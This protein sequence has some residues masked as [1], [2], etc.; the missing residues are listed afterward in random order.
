VV[1]PH[2]AEEFLV[3]FGLLFGEI[4]LAVV[5]LG[6]GGGE[7]GDMALGGGG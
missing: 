1:A 4:F 3:L 6:V 7:R 5:L 2:R